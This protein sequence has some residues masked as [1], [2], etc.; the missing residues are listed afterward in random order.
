MTGSTTI[1]P[2]EI[3]RPQSFNGPSAVLKP[4][5]SRIASTSISISRVVVFG[6]KQADAFDRAVADDLTNLKG[7]MQ[8]DM[9]LLCCGS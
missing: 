2:L 1:A 5:C 6:M 7:D 4:S 8:I 9:S 3:S